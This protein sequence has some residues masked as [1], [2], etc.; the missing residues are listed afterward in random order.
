MVKISQFAII[1]AT[2]AAAASASFLNLE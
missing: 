2:F 1:A